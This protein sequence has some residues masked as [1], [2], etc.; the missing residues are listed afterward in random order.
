MS[1]VYRY[2]I[3]AS[4][5]VAKTMDVVYTTDGKAP[6]YMACP[7]PTSGTDVTSVIVQYAPI[8]MWAEM[9]R[10]VENVIV[11]TSGIIDATPLV[12]AQ[13]TPVTPTTTTA[14]PF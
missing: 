3:V 14:E 10:Q 8:Q 7:L 12:D 13:A 1:Y 9:D 11:G 6:V 4:D 5:L 2:E